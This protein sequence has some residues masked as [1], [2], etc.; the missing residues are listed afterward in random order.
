MS[1]A[2]ILVGLAAEQ[3]ESLLKRVRSPSRDASA[4]TVDPQEEL[5]RFR[6][7]GQRLQF[8]RDD[9][10]DEFLRIDFF[11]RGSGFHVGA[12]ER[13]ELAHRES[14]ASEP[15]AQLVLQRLVAIGAAAA[16]P[17]DETLVWCVFE[18]ADQ[19][20]GGRLEPHPRL[21]ER[22]EVEVET[23]LAFPPFLELL[24]AEDPLLQ[25]RGH[26]GEAE[27]DQQRAVAV[28]QRGADPAILAL[29]LGCLSESGLADQDE[30]VDVCQLGESFRIRRRRREEIGS[31]RHESRNR[32]SGSPVPPAAKSGSR[33]S[34]VPA[35]ADLSSRIGAPGARAGCTLLTVARSRSSTA[36]RSSYSDRGEE[37]RYSNIGLPLGSYVGGFSI[38]QGEE[39]TVPSHRH[40]LVR[41]APH[42]A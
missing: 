5:Q 19:E 27:F 36:A 7:H 30:A 42:R 21:V 15:P 20:L 34:S 29:E 10:A 33:G 9:F 14:L 17:D 22:V 37:D 35:R 8:A 38:H 2:P 6:D 32:A 24:R 41:S 39:G 25:L 4:L 1:G 3:F 18:S 28:P 11:C 40:P 16:E 23:S 13:R 26:P 31:I 12:G